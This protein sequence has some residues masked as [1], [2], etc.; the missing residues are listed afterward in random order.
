MSI[1]DV[2]APL[3]GKQIVIT[4]P[5]VQS[6]ELVAKLERLGATVTA[7]PTIKTVPVSSYEALDRAVTHLPDYDYLVFTS[8]NAVRFF[9]KRWEELTRKPSVP[10]NL[11]VA[12]IGPSTAQA[13]NK[14]GWRVD[15]IPE[16]HRAEGVIE[17]LKQRGLA[18]KKVLLPRAL[19]A[20]EILPDELRAAG[21]VV[22][23]IPVY[24][25][26]PEESSSVEMLRRL[27]LKEVDVIAF[28]SAS[29]VKNFFRLLQDKIDLKESLTGVKIASIGPVTA[30][31]AAELGLKVD[32]VAEE[33]TA[34]GLVAA[35]VK[36]FD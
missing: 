17:A 16:E 9:L 11:R 18:G 4:R 10:A 5:R 30:N 15:I 21:A 35:I 6:E 13:L 1:P 26:V 28:T 20:R 31:S 29:T 33:Y 19:V 32:I 14:A 36:L 34:D 7:L 27:K 23:V 3:A 25:T 24:Q 22:E 8:A 12:A 2:A